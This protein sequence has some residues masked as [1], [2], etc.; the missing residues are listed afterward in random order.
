MNKIEMK[1][2]NTFN[3]KIAVYGLLIFAV[4]LSA[5][6]CRYDMQDQP[7]YKAYKS[8]DFFSDDKAMRDLPDGTVARGQLRDNK[9]FY[10]GKK[11]NAHMNAIPLWVF[12]TQPSY[13]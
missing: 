3:K 13:I 8:S 10:T 4:C 9:A 6:G 12:A 1:N 5:I 7:R 2:S 11:E